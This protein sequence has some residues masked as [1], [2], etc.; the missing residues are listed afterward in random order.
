V[1]ADATH[2]TKRRYW[3]QRLYSDARAADG[4]IEP[5]LPMAWDHPYWNVALDPAVVAAAPGSSAP[6]DARLAV[7]AYGDVGTIRWRASSGGADVQPPSGTAHAGDTIPITITPLDSLSTGQ[8]VEIDVI[9]ESAAGG[10]QLWIG[11]VQAR[12]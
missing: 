2:P 11:Y 6:I 8:S 7:F 4:T 5:C 10:S 1:P 3:L 12:Q 9:S